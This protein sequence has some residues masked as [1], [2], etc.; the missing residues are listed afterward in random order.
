MSLTFLYL[1][2]TLFTTLKLS[3][4]GQTQI[5]EIVFQESGRAGRDDKPAKCILFYRF[6]DIFRLSTMVFTEQTGLEKLYGIVA[7]CLDVPRLVV[8]IRRLLSRRS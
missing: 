7:Y 3:L 6:A 8:P 1:S 4:K 5:D 2:L